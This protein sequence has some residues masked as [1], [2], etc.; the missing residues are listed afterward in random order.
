MLMLWPQKAL[1]GCELGEWQITPQSIESR[2]DFRPWVLWHVSP[3]SSP[4][5]GVQ[6]P[7]DRWGLSCS[8]VGGGGR[9]SQSGS[10]VG[11]G[12]LVRAIGLA[13]AEGQRNEAG[14]QKC[15][16]KNCNLIIIIWNPAPTPSSLFSVTK[17]PMNDIVPYPWYIYI[18]IHIHAYNIYTYIHTGR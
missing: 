2:L 8:W 14:L 17:Q 5:L 7:V 18:C 3:P 11:N 10:V 15:W 9:W 13:G 1:F 16:E 6:L 4:P 12:H